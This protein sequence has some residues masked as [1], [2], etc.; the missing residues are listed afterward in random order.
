MKISTTIPVFNTNPKYL[1]EA[2]GSVLNQTYGVDE[3]ILVND[4]ST[5]TETLQELYNIHFWFKKNPVKVLWQNNK[6]I[7]GALNTGIRNMTGDWWTGCSSDDRWLPN[8]IE[9][10]VKFIEAHPEAK[11][12]YSDWEF[13]DNEGFRIKAYYEPEFKDRFEAGKHIIREYFGN[14][15][16]LMIH[17]SVFDDIGLF[18]EAYPTREDYEFAIRVLTKHM[19]YRIPKI[20]FQYRL[21]D[22]QITNS[23]KFGSR[24]AEAKKYCEMARALAIEHFGDEEDR[25]QF[26]QGGYNK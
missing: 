16:G 21:H 24:T 10:Q 25:K 17:K 6:K 22:E 3:I 1:C 12:I 13:I 20:L 7:S 11:V 2:L 18:N 15:S 9:E 5:R 23:V 26:S 8:K 14:W 19:M 4:G